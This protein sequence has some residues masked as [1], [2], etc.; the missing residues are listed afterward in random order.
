MMNSVHRGVSLTDEYPENTITVQDIV[1]AINRS[2]FTEY[3][4]FE[5]GKLLSHSAPILQVA[6]TVNHTQGNGMYSIL[7]TEDGM[8]TEYTDKVPFEDRI[9]FK[10]VPNLNLSKIDHI[11]R[12]QTVYKYKHTINYDRNG[13]LMGQ[14]LDVDVIRISIFLN[15]IRRKSDCMIAKIKANEKYLTN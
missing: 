1:D 4:R 11:D 15:G 13:E 2:T 6:I 3:A 7:F 12:F 14:R 5:K 10:K 9:G 8:F